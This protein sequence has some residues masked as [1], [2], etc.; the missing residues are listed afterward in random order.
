M[1]RILYLLLALLLVASLMTSCAKEVYEQ[2][3]DSSEN[4]GNESFQGTQNESSLNDKGNS[5]GNGSST[6]DTE[7]STTADKKPLTKFE[8]QFS[9]KNEEIELIA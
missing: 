2:W 8:K 6:K 7:K 5:N 9:V 1:K 4:M 3:S